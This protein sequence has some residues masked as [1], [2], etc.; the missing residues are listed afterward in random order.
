MLD[1]VIPD[2]YIAGGTTINAYW[3]SWV[4]DMLP[5]EGFEPQDEY[6]P[7]QT[8]GCVQKVVQECEAWRSSLEAWQKSL[9]NDHPRTRPPFPFS[10]TRKRVDI[11][12][13]TIPGSR[14]QV[15]RPPAML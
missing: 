2:A 5:S 14:G 12:L 1:L 4:H 9:L 7:T 6:S 3:R 13:H 8:K 11:H 15:H 10:I